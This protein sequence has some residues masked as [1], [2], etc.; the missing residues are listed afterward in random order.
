MSW[1]GV[2]VM[3]WGEWG[4]GGCEVGD[5]GFGVL[6]RDGTVGCVVGWFVGNVWLRK[7]SELEVWECIIVLTLYISCRSETLGLGGWGI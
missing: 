4:F 5:E 2:C 1:K 3:R 6:R 7:E